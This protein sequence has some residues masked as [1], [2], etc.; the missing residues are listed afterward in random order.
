LRWLLSCAIGLGLP[1]LVSD[2]AKGIGWDVGYSLYLCVA[3]GGLIVGVWQAFILRGRLR[4]A[5][6][7]VAGSVVGW[8][9]ASGMVALADSLSKSHS[10]RGIWG[11]IA[12]LG[13]AAGG[14]LVLG[15]VTATSLVLLLRRQPAVVEQGPPRHG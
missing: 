9:L 7:W 14:G 5:G 11:A 4:N 8:T 10:L 15:I 12:Y 2:I 1:F 3:L 6:W 13:T